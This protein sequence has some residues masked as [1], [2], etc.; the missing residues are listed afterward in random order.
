MESFLCHANQ[1]HTVVDS[2][3]TKPALWGELRYMSNNNTPYTHTHT[4]PSPQTHTCTQTHT[5]THTRA[6]H[7]H[8]TPIHSH[9]NTHKHANTHT[10]TCTCMHAHTHTCG[11]CIWP[12][13]CRC[14]GEC[15][16]RLLDATN[17]SWQPISHTQYHLLPF[18]FVLLKFKTW[19]VSNFQ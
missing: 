11:C 19:I 5:H 6:Y 7:T 8:H 17:L 10:H 9:T 18:Y 12:T 15:W 2:T 14:V 13:A 1:P 3:R 4:Y 16:L